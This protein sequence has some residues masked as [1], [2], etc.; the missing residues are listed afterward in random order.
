MDEQQVWVAPGDPSDMAPLPAIKHGDTLFS[1][2]NRREQAFGGM[3]EHLSMQTYDTFEECRTAM[4][5]ERSAMLEDLNKHCRHIAQSIEHIRTIPPA[6]FPNVGREVREQG[7]QQ[8]EAKAQEEAKTEEVKPA[9]G[10]R[11]RPSR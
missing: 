9:P 10:L 4:I 2:Y 7:Q 1:D 8:E 11:K 6:P 5:A 3:Y